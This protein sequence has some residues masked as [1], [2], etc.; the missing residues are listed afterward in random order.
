MSKNL[1]DKGNLDSPLLLYNRSVQRSKD[2]QE[3]LPSG[4][5]EV[6]ESIADG[7]AKAE[8]IFTCIADDDAVRELYATAT[9][10]VDIKGKL[11]VECSTIHPST[12]EEIAKR[13][14]AA[15]AEFVAVPVFGA[16]A[17]AEAGQL[18]AV[19]AGPSASVARAKPWFK[20]VMARA[21]I[22]LSDQPVGKATTLKVLGNTYI[23]NMVEQLAEMHVVAEKSGLGTELLHQ[24]IETMFPGPSSAYSTRMVT[25]DYHKRAEPLF[26]VDLARKDA[27]HAKD[28]AAAAGA[29]LKNVETADEHLA[30][31]K[32][33]AG[34]KGDIAGIYGAARMEAGLKFENDV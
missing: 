10:G 19:L 25:G 6:V 4:K 5:S 17:A 1:V 16:P 2:L 7:V 32:E 9:Q 22:D 33:H 28:L 29:T 15:G 31:V 21:E 23:I 13:V 11:F 34:P 12:S 24:F 20:G 18:V 3:S 27:R 14:V 26:A 30:A 8:V